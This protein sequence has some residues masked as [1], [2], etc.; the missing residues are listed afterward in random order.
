MAG[1][2]RIM[3]TSVYLA[4]LGVPKHEGRPGLSQTELIKEVENC[5]SNDDKIIIPFG[6][7]IESGNH[8]SRSVNGRRH[9]II[10]KFVSD[11][12]DALEGKAP[13][14][15]GELGSEDQLYKWLDL[16]QENANANIEFGDTICIAEFHRLH[17]MFPSNSIKIWSDDVHLKSYKLVP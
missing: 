4:L 16:F 15:I 6:T 13:Y 1:N 11:V 2:I 7:I 5:L 9:G 14:V 10:L 17:E 12:K 3:D 8:I